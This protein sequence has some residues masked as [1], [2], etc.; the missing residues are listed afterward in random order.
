VLAILVAFRWTWGA[1]ALY[2]LVALVWLIPE[3]RI[4]RA[5]DAARAA[6]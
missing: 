4:E 1:Q 3:R 6:R 2:V 5:L